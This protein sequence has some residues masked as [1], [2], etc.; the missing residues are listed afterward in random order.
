MSLIAAKLAACGIT[1]PTPTPPL[2]AYVPYVITG[3]M[4][5]ISGQLPMEN[6]AVKYSG[7]FAAATI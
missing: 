1:L 3:D 4:V 6:G 2:A 7:R 5:V